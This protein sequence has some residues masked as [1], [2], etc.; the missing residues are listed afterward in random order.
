MLTYKRKLILNKAQQ[1]RIDSWIGTCRFIYNMCLEIRISAYKNKQESVHKYALG[2]QLTEIRNVDWIED[3]PRMTLT[4]VI[5]RMDKAYKSFFNG[6]GFPRW[7]TKR[8]YTSIT[9]IKSLYVSGDKIKIPKIGWLKIF[10]DAPISGNIKTI[11]IKKE[12]TGYYA[13]ITTDAVKNIQNKDENQ[14]LGLDMGV[15][16]FAVDSNGQFISNPR[17]FKAHERKLRVENRS[18]SRKKKG[19]R[20]WLK[21]AR[22]VALLHHKIGNIRKDFL[23]KESTKIAKANNLVIMEDLNIRGMIKSNLSK[24]I[25]DCGWGMFRQ[26]L[27]YKTTVVAINPKFTSQI[28]NSCGEKDAKSRVSQSEFVCTFCGEKTN[29]DENAAKNILSK[30]LAHVRERKA[31]A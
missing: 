13:C 20:N 26:M 7:A 31:I 24:H 16:H 12:I 1:S 2:K 22:K 28:C 5:E 6:A 19:G 18:L 25:S 10:K 11:T 9:L 21:Q 15:A 17:H 14:V 27:E 3:V 23:H 8:T 4:D 29:A 30:G